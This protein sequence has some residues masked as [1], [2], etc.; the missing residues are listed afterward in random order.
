[1]TK[2]KSASRSNFFRSH[3]GLMAMG[4]AAKN[5]RTCKWLRANIGR[6]GYY[7]RELDLHLPQPADDWDDDDELED[8]DDSYP[9]QYEAIKYPKVYQKDAPL[10]RRAD[11]VDI[12][13]VGAAP[14]V[15]F[16]IDKGLKEYA[17][18]RVGGG[19]EPNVAQTVVNRVAW[20]LTWSWEQLGR[21]RSEFDEGG[22]AIIKKHFSDMFVEAG[23]VRLVE[24]FL[25][26]LGTVN[27]RK[28]G[29]IA[30]VVDDLDR[31]VQWF[32]NEVDRA[33]GSSI[34]RIRKQLANLRLSYRSEHAKRVVKVRSLL[35]HN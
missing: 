2:C 22:E 32:C 30:N 35:Y 11:R 31:A 10:R 9:Q 29:T 27:Q 26:S 12:A 1:M 19:L 34:E 5:G 6:T 8:G 16:L 21:Q 20:F 13:E 24:A 18:S 17:E 28:P 14:V 33:S 4:I 15:G 25:K 23:R 7:C 3:H